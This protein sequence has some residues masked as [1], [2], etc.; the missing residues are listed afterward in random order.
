MP[1]RYYAEQRLLD[2]ASANRLK[3]DFRRH[4]RVTRERQAEQ[5]MLESIRRVR[6]LSLWLPYRTQ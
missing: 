5:Q 6:H 3:D 4:D 2:T 1:R